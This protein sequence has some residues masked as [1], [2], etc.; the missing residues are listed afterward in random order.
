MPGHVTDVAPTLLQ[1]AGVSHPEQLGG[2]PVAP[3]QGRSLVSLFE[4]G[5]PSAGRFEQGWELFG[6]KAYRQG[7]WKIVLDA[8][9][10]G[11]GDWQLFN[12][13]TDR[14]EQIDLA[15]QHAEKLAEKIRISGGGRCNFT[16]L[17]A[18]P[19]N[20]LSQNPHF[21]RS[22]LS[23]YTPQDFIALVERYGIAY[24]EKTLG[25]LFCDGSARQVVAMLRAEPS[26]LPPALNPTS[27]RTGFD[28]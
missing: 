8:P 16:N 5:V 25:Q 24:H 28:G 3:L 18:G 12:L 23:R 9:P 2:R 26:A 14:A 13:R 19:Q 27:R 11:T 20:Y 22:A 4:G 21:C 10:T 15:A 1:L 7:D 6:R 17:D